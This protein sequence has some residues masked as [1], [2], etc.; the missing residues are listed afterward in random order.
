[1][2]LALCPAEFCV[3]SLFGYQ[4]WILCFGVEKNDICYLESFAFRL[5]RLVNILW[6]AA[7]CAGRDGV[8]LARY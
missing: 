7:Y 3:L 4:Y 8:A 6:Q 2:L 1:M 5:T